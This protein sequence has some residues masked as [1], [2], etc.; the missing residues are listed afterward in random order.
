MLLTGT[1]RL[2]PAGLSPWAIHVRDGRVVWVGDPRDA[3]ADDARV[4]LG[5]ALVTPGLVDSHTHPVFAGD[6]SDEVA[7]RLAR[8]PNNQWLIKK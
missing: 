6:R 4:D 5:H 7:A 3:P 2:A 8:A 1:G